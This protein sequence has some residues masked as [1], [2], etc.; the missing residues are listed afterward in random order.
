MISKIEEYLCPESGLKLTLKGCFF[1]RAPRQETIAVIQNDFR[2]TAEKAI[3]EVTNNPMPH[4]TQ[5]TELAIKANEIKE[6]LL[7]QFG[8]HSQH[9]LVT[10]LGIIT[11]CTTIKSASSIGKEA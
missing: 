10:T 5:M 3:R 1:S 7:S 8:P 4:N 2:H 6:R 11:E 9:N